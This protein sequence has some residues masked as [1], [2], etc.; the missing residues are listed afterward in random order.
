M[1]E[2]KDDKGEPAA[3]SPA[4]ET[5]AAPD[6]AK[7][8]KEGLGLLWQAARG[9]ASEIQREVVKAGIGGHIRAAAGEI[10]SAAQAASKELE[11]FIARVAP[12]P[13]RYQSDWPPKP[14][15]TATGAEASTSPSDAVPMRIVIEPADKDETGEPKT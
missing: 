7:A 10:E 11:S 14:S 3:A 8:V 4:V 15:T 6:P 2:A 13:P 5:K 1:T 9:A 12:P